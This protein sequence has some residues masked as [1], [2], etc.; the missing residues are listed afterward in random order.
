MSG[1]RPLKQLTIEYL[2][3]SVTPF[4]LDFE[5]GRKLTIIYGENGSGK[6]TICDALDFLGNGKV[7]SLENRG[8]NRTQPFWPSVGRQ[9]EEVAVTLE[10]ST[11]KCRATLAAG[12]VV[13]APAEARPRVLVMRRA[14]LLDLVQATP[15][16]RYEAIRR[17]VDVALFE[18]SEASLRQLRLDLE[19]GR[20][21]ASARVGENADEIRRMWDAAGK[22]PTDSLEWAAAE[23]AR[24]T[25]T[26]E[27]E[28][29]KLAAL[30]SAFL[31][32]ADGQSALSSAAAALRASQERAATAQAEVNSCLLGLAS[33]AGELAAVLE[34]AQSYLAG[35]VGP[36]V[37]PVCESGERAVGLIDRVAARLEPLSAMRSAQANLRSA[38]EDARRKEESR[39]LSSTRL[40]SIAAAFNEASDADSFPADVPRASDAA[41]SECAAIPTWLESN[42]GLPGEWKLAEAKRIENKKFG[43]AL[44][45]AYIAWRENYDEQKRLDRWLPRIEATL[46]VLGEERRHFADAQ[47][48]AISQEAGRLYELVHPGEGLNQIALQ[49][50]P[51]KRASLE[52]G[53]SFGGRQTLP[54]AYFSDS[55]LDTLGLCIYLAL[56]GLEHPEET[57]VALDDVLA[58]VDEPHVERLVEMI[59][60]EA[61]KFQHCILTTHYRPWK[62]KLLWGWLKPGQCQFVE[63]AKW[64]AFDGLSLT[65]SVPQVER[66]RALLTEV[67]PDLQAICSKAGV[68]LEAALD[69]L[70]R[71]YECRLPYRPGGPYVLREY[72]EA[73]SGKLKAALRIERLR[74]SDP[75]G[76]PIY[77][78]VRLAPLLDEITRIAQVRNV[79]GCHF[80]EI[81]F[82]LLDSEALAF[83]HQVLGLI[84]AL[85]D[86]ENG[87]PRNDK[88]GSYWAT[89]GETRKLH[90][91][92]RPT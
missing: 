29:R 91:L 41:P 23:S 79:V 43:T 76:D 46:R 75:N 25:S 80:R 32:I 88:S 35:H 6:S 49:L 13:T 8:L 2:R 42:A 68:I 48:G 55:H 59:Y 87:W 89:A 4:A 10:T 51:E 12:G 64:S 21:V 5:R 70:T 82:E 9:A 47:L 15:S 40:Q 11:V 74:G 22:P 45:A 63:M 54:Q 52:I 65:R 27:P 57:I 38:N 92:K 84:D 34:A 30:Q 26:L 73:L 17:F 90:P 66:L 77:E 39:S 85:T 86:D 44:R 28:L 18:K 71:R 24:D 56:A 19:R 1:S 78:N 36:Q 62:E 14:T 37:C 69:F 7:G 58:S 53:A 31:R 72:L 16:L 20:E 60:T 3:G 81:S 33:D 61:S 50:D 83:A 67:H